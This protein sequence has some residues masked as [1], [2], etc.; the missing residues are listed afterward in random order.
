MLSHDV[1]STGFSLHSLQLA[2]LTMNMIKS[3]TEVPRQFSISQ[4]I[5]ITECLKTEIQSTEI[6]GMRVGIKLANKIEHEANSIKMQDCFIKC[7]SLGL[8]MSESW[9]QGKNVQQNRNSKSKSSPSSEDDS[10]DESKQETEEGNILAVNPRK[11][12]DLLSKHMVEYVV[13]NIFLKA[14]SIRGLIFSVIRYYSISSEPILLF[15]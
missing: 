1:P 14:M 10:K 5:M 9:N 6:N 12:C 15:I 8:L 3:T 4:G 7:C 2:K 11:L 13:P